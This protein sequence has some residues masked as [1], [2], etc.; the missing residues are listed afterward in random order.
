MFRNPPPPHFSTGAPPRGFQEAMPPD[1]RDHSHHSPLT[2]PGNHLGQAPPSPH[3]ISPPSMHH[4][5]TTSSTRDSQ[6]PGAWISVPTNSLQDPPSD[7]SMPS[8]EISA[9]FVWEKKHMQRSFKVDDSPKN[10]EDMLTQTCPRV[11]RI[12]IPPKEWIVDIFPPS[13]D[14]TGVVDMGAPLEDQWPSTKD[15]FLK[16]KAG[17][18]SPFTIQIRADPV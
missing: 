2:H 17:R 16:H 13:G 3:R 14:E 6:P 5:P 18:E 4:Q 7:T 11:L 12:S 9:K 8:V 15:F 1:V 10:L